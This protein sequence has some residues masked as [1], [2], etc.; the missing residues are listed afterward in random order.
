MEAFWCYGNKQGTYQHYIMHKSMCIFTN[1]DDSAMTFYIYIRFWWYACTYVLFTRF[2]FA[3]HYVNYSSISADFIHVPFKPH[4]FSIKD[5]FAG[6]SHLSWLCF[7][8]S[9]NEGCKHE[10]HLRRVKT[11]ASWNSFDWVVSPNAKKRIWK[12]MNE[13]VWKCMRT[14]DKSECRPL[15]SLQFCNY[16]QFPAGYANDHWTIK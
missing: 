9:L 3:C 4:H 1:N 14:L 16:P 10:T 7:Q 12:I 11:H 8:H 15:V 6:M 5:K 2:S 13:R